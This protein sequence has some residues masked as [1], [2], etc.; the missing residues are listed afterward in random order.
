MSICRQRLNA[1]SLLLV[2]SFQQID[3][4]PQRVDHPQVEFMHSDHVCIYLQCF[5]AHQLLTM[6]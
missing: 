3:E 4:P 6:C 1:K 5:D 2:Q